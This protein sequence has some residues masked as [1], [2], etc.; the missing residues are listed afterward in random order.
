MSLLV[1]LTIVAI[2]LGAAWPLW[3]GGQPWLLVAVGV[4]AALVVG[5][6]PYLVQLLVERHQRRVRHGRG[7]GELLASGPDQSAAWLLHPANEVVSFTGRDEQLR[8]LRSWCSQKT[9]AVVRLVVAPG[10]YGKTRLARQFAATLA[11]G[12]WQVW[13]VRPTGEADLAQ[14][15]R[16]Q[17]PAKSTLIVIDYAETREPAALGALIAAAVNHRGRVRLL[18]L[19]RTAGAWWSGLSRWCPQYPALIDSLTIA[20]NVIDLPARVD[21]HT[22]D[23]IIALAAGDFA[24]HLDLAVPVLTPSGY[25]PDSPLLRLHAYALLAVLGAPP[26]GGTD[27]LA[28]VLTHEARYWYARAR[29]AHPPL[30]PDTID[31]T[32]TAVLLGQLVGIAALCG[33]ATDQQTTQL[34]RRTPALAGADDEQLRR[35][36]TWLADLYPSDS[37]DTTDRGAGSGLGTLQPDLLAEHLAMRTLTACTTTQITAI[38]DGLSHTQAV[39]VLTVLGRARTSYPSLDVV[40]PA[41]LGAD[42]S[43]M[44][45]AVI[46]VARQ[47]PGLYTPTIVTQ[48]ASADLTPERLRALARQV[49]Y[50]SIELSP[51]ALALTSRIAHPNQPAT[52]PV[53]RAFW[54]DWHTLRLAEAGRRAE[55]L[56]VSQEAVTLRRELTKANR[57]AYLPHLATSV[58]NHATFLAEAGRRAEALTVSQE[59]VTLRRELTKANRDAYLPDLAT[60]VNNHA[61]R[62]AEAGRRAEAL[63]VSQ[64]AVTLYR[65]LAEANRDAYLPDLAMSV[66]NHANRLAEA[67]RRAEALTVS[68]EAV[69]LYREL[70]EANRDAYLPDLAMSVNNHANRLAEAGRRAEALIVSQEAVTLRRELVEA[71]RDA[72]LP[73]LATS[74]NNHALRLAE[75]GRRAEALIVSQEA[76][77]LRRELVEANRDAYLPDLAMSVNNHALR[78]A[79]AGR[80]AEALIVSQEAVTLYRELVEA[81]RDAYLPDLAMSVNNHALRLAEAGRRAEALIVSQEALTLRR[82]LVEANRDAYLP[83]LAMSVNN[84]ALRLAEAGR[85]AEALIVSQEAVTLYRELVEANRDA[86]LPDLATSVNNHALRLAE[87]GRRAEAL[88]VSQEA[89]TLYR[90]L[91][92]AN[93]DAYLP[94]LATSLWTFALVRQSLGTELGMAIAAATQAEAIFTELAATEP[95]AFT[96][97]RNA[98]ANIVTE[99]SATDTEDD[100]T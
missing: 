88:I 72:Y 93:R 64:E 73:D 12:G 66:N 4:A 13:P 6:G 1:S 86:Y 92:E 22:T 5:L 41:V 17:P 100:P 78:L 19:A 97:R 70:A 14:T 43:T 74:V 94:D 50:P 2:A 76:V 9:A 20:A 81:N 15:I 16:E 29:R 34:V 46:T 48:L 60:S 11:A 30:L 91:V 33:A 84:H 27:V 10:G 71:N 90:E 89:V 61:N 35:W 40:L 58:N 68:Q 77:T 31:E 36:A 57:D 69:T 23:E 7:R 62:L 99:L 45:E 79:E 75:A 65:E 82:E 87:A 21:A 44:T 39:Q 51:I 83:D 37:T 47:F 63:T 49:P 18:L 28:E 59:A 3:T 53:D 96:E 98:V 67:G 52:G 38:V 54:L 8:E 25:P 80:R 26:P 55:A 32:R 95:D 56:I 42:V 24:E 85:R